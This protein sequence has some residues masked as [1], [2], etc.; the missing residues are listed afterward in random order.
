M[1]TV[2]AV[3]SA[4]GGVGKTTTAAA[5]ATAL[6]TAGERVVAIDADLGTPTLAATL[7]VTTDQPT[8]HDVLAG[9]A[10]LDEATVSGPAG[11]QLV[12]GALDITA[13]AAADPAGLDAL[14]ESVDDAATVIVDTG[15]GLT[16]DTARVLAMADETLLVTTDDARALA[17]TDTTR[18]LTERLGGHVAGAV[19]C[20]SDPL[21]DA[22]TSALQATVLGYVPEDPAVDAAAAVGAPLVTFAPDAPATEAYRSLAS[23]L[24][25]VKMGVETGDSTAVDP[26]SSSD[27]DSPD[28]ADQDT[29]PGPADPMETELTGSQADDTDRGF[30]SRLFG[31]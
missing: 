21:D 29:D 14:I 18:Q 13:Y 31:R 5:L 16:H 23:Q 19:C 8:V 9:D 15:A 6:A 30:L 24:T 26:D 1:G 7:G 28:P 12:A 10:T 3:A 25:G 22:P 2:Y 17:S 27:P 20:R 11:M 4:K